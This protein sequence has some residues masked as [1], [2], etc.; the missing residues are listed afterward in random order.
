ME[1]GSNCVIKIAFSVWV[2]NA[3]HLI[4]GKWDEIGSVNDG[5]L[6]L[7]R[8]KLVF[9]AVLETLAFDFHRGEHQTV[10]DK[11]R[12]ITNSFGRFEA[13]IKKRKLII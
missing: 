8:L 11:V 4:R 10:A 12:C 9:H 5:L 6:Y 2:D 1:N 3:V 7:S 13:V